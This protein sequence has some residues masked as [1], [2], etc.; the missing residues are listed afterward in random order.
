M[1]RS[2][3]TSR[4]FTLIEIT[5]GLAVAALVMSMGVVAVNSLTDAALRSAAV[6]LTGA[7]KYSYDRSIMLNRIQRIGFDIDGGSWW[8]E[9]TQDPFRLDQERSEGELGFTRDEEGNLVREGDED[10]LRD[11]GIDEYTDD[12]VRKA[13]RAA[14]ARA[15]PLKRMTSRESCR[16]ASASAVSG[17][18]IKKSRSPQ[19]SAFCTSS[20]VGGP[21]PR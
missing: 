9:Y 8:L 11:L 1:T 15:S 4:G 18:G 2:R 13:S 5:I 21:S 14:G 19:G 16:R 3:S 6:E 17:P 10:R 12:E 20:A 7:I